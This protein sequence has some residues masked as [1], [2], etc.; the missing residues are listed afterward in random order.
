MDVPLLAAE[1]RVRRGKRVEETEVVS[2]MY[3]ALVGANRKYLR[4]YGIFMLAL[5]LALACYQP[6][7]NTEIANLTSPGRT[8]HAVVFTRGC[9]AGTSRT[10]TMVSLLPADAPLPGPDEVG[11]VFRV[12]N[13]GADGSRAPT[14]GQ[15]AWL[16][17]SVLLIRHRPTAHVLFAVRHDHGVT[18][19]YDTLR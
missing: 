8:R 10:G 16:S 9:G 3:G 14:E 18:I 6:C 13:W 5:A 19:Q 4:Q 15:A 7:S 2:L 12:D 17:D 1:S 11:N